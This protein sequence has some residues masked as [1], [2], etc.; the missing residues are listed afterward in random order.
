MEFEWDENKNNINKAKHGVSFENATRVFLDE[1]RV[2]IYDD[3]NSKENED[4]FITIGKAGKLLYVVFTERED[5]TRIISARLAEKK[6][7]ETYYGNR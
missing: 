2:E 5:R 1:N 4:R 3:K 7:K 6:E